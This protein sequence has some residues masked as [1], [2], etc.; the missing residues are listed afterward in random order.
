MSKIMDNGEI[1]DMTP[2]EQAQFDKDQASPPAIEDEVSAE[3][4]LARLEALLK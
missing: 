3:E 1:R 2:E 4:L